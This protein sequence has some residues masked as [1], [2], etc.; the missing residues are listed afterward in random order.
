MNENQASNQ[1]ISSSP[2]HSSIVLGIVM[3]GTLMGALGQHYC[4][5][6]FS[7]NK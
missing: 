6:G 4:F 5:A 1:P 3:L 2:K 7:S